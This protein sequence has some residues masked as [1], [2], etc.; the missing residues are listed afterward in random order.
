MS[1][2]SNLRTAVIA[3]AAV[4]NIG[5][6]DVCY[7]GLGCFSNETPF[8]NAAGSLPQSPEEVGVVFMLY[9][10]NSRLSPQILSTEPALIRA[11][12]FSGHR[13]SVLIVHGF[14][15][16]GREDWLVDMKDALLQMEDLNVIIVD[17]E[18]GA[19]ALEYNQAVANCRVVGAMT[20]RLLQALNEQRKARYSD[21]HII[22]HSLGAHVAGYVGERIASLGRITGLDPA[23]LAFEGKPD[24]VRL[25]PSDADFVDV[26]HTDGQPVTSLGF[27]SSKPMGDADFYPNGGKDQPGCKSAEKHLIKLIT[28]KFKSFQKGVGCDHTRARDYFIESIYNRCN[29]SASKCPDFDAF[30]RGDCPCFLKYCARMGYY[31]NPDHTGSFYLVTNGTAPFCVQ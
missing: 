25:D 20:A 17:W 19:G 24:N 31:A 18:K 15:D 11:S 29:F 4:L 6:K 23:G 2:F 22:G 10:R 26:I 9:T 27:G 5:S 8:N 14:R 1:L 13:K 28:G 16:D 30:I 3:V 12:Y 21:M 7:E